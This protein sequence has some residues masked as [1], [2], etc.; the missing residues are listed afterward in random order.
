MP[1]EFSGSVRI[2]YPKWSRAEIIERLL[3]RMAEL[4]RHL[5]LRKVVLFGSYATGNYTVGSDV[6]P[7]VIYEGEPRPDAYALVKRILDIPGLEP[8]LYTQKEYEAM[9][10]TVEKMIAGGI[11]IYEGSQTFEEDKS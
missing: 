9:R 6:D 7:L 11:V 5:P 1:E 4:S 8:H 3:A 2:F 10:E